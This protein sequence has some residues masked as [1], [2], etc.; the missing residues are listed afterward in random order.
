[1]RF[2]YAKLWKLLI[3]KKMV[4]R[5]LMEAT[6]VTSSTIAKMGKEQPVALE[7]LGRVCKALNCNIGD[8][9]DVL[10]DD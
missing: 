10:F 6:G 4:K 1:M 2:S 5:D 8:V 9:V 7:V 3:D